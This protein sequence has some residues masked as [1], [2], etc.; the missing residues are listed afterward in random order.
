MA[1]GTDAM[2][3][4]GLPSSR[5]TSPGAGRK[6]AGHEAR[7]FGQSH[8]F[9]RSDRLNVRC[10]LALGTRRDFERDL[11]SFLQ[12]LET[13]HVDRR[14]MREEIFAATIGSNE[15]KAFG[16]VEP[17]HSACCHVSQS[18]NQ[19]IIGSNPADV[20]IKDRKVRLF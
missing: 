4:E 8:C 5:G 11:L 3:R 2:R 16:V 7:L 12:G 9:R 6:K 19:K 18:S 13:R 15:A 14:E 1:G 20:S 10:L 17:L